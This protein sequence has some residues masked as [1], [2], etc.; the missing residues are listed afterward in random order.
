LKENVSDKIERYVTGIAG[1]NEKAEVE[2]LFQQGENY[3]I[4]FTICVLTYI[5]A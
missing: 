4:L 3:S 5:T 2:T 1:G